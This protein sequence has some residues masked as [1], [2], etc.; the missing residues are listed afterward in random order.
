MDDASYSFKSDFVPPEGKTYAVSVAHIRKMR[1]IHGPG[2]FQIVFMTEGW[3]DRTRKP[4]DTLTLEGVDSPSDV[5][6][7]D[8]DE[9]FQLVLARLYY[10]NSDEGREVKYACKFLLK[11]EKGKIDERWMTFK[12][13]VAAEEEEEEEEEE[14][15]EEEREDRRSRTRRFRERYTPRRTMLEEEVGLTIDNAMGQ[16]LSGVIEFQGEMREDIRM[17]RRHTSDALGKL[18]SIA[19]NMTR[20]FDNQA[21]VNQAGWDALHLGLDMQKQVYKSM[22]ELREENAGLIAEN[23]ALQKEGKDNSRNTL[24]GT[25]I[26]LAVKAMGQAMG[27]RNGMAG[28]LASAMPEAEVVS[29]VMA[30]AGLSQDPPEQP[31]R[32]Q[33]KTVDIYELCSADEISN[34]PLTCL[35]RM[36]GASIGEGQDVALKKVLSPSEWAT[37]VETFGSKNDDEAS[38]GMMKF[39]L[40]F[41][42]DDGTRYK[43]VV[44]TLTPFQRFLLEQ[45]VE[46][47]EAKIG[48]KAMPPLDPSHFTTRKPEPTVVV[49][50]VEK[51][52][53]AP[54]TKRRSRFR[55]RRRSG[56]AEAE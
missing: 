39:F 36:L 30:N 27:G 8:Q 25:I 4:F 7:V 21:R 45:L 13:D 6:P 49:R 33:A 56:Q 18:F 14:D 22:I 1:G 48:G 38:M 3:K 19:E 42:G 17:S 50:Q 43:A 26:P 32:P 46:R 53:E 54:E 47:A 29:E 15:E 52:E 31:Q 44:Q 12:L 34:H 41:Q 10:H 2:L 11:R 28:A 55:S 9:L 23:E 16:F 5:P 35:S 37:F 40:S 20:H 24:L 51:G